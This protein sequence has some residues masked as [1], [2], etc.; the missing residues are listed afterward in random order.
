MPKTET[1]VKKKKEKEEIEEENAEETDTDETKT[2]EETET[3]E[4]EVKK[5]PEKPKAKPMPEEEMETIKLNMSGKKEIWQGIIDKLIGL[6]NDVTLKF[7]KN[8]IETR[9]TDEGSVALVE[10]QVKKNAFDEYSISHEID[11]GVDLTKLQ[12]H[13]KA[14]QTGDLTVTNDKSKL[15]F[16]G[17][18]GKTSRMGLLDNSL[19]NDV[20]LPTMAFEVQTKTPFSK[21]SEMVKISSEKGFDVETLKF[22]VKDSKF[23]ILM[24]GE[25]DNVRF[26]ICAINNLTGKKN[27]C[28]HYSRKYLELFSFGS[29]DEI[30]VKFGK[31]IPLYLEHDDG[32]E[33]TTYL[34]APRIETDTDK[35][36]KEDED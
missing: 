24:E 12:K 29:D 1:I 14:H 36:E 20:K 3:E 7:T 22:S 33:H 19:Y 11:I 28:T 31:D 27:F 10:H 8:G 4:V 6:R 32:K 16:K 13:I 30:M 25:T 35:E 2:D 18:S 9:L 34:L 15:V 23:S 5:K 26:P 21:I 17:E